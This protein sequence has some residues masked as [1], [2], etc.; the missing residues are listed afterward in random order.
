MFIN[1]IYYYEEHATQLNKV[2]YFVETV[3]H[4]NIINIIHDLTTSKLIPYIK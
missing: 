1:G 2:S 4:Y 3:H